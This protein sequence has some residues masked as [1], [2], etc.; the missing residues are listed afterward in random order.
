MNATRKRGSCASRR[1]SRCAR[2]VACSAR[3]APLSATICSFAIGVSP[4]IDG[5]DFAA[6]EPCPRDRRGSAHRRR[7]R[8]G[9]TPPR[10]GHRRAASGRAPLPRI[11]R[12]STST[13]PRMI[14][15]SDGAKA[16]AARTAPGARQLR[17]QAIEPAAR[18]GGMAGAVLHDELGVEMRARR[19]G[20]AR[21]MD[22]GERPAC[23]KGH[24]AA[25]APDAG[26]TVPSRSG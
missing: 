8:A 21:G 20:R 16:D 26:R 4:A 1:P 18:A 2:T 19:L 14:C 22:E 23:H 10:S 24:H 9:R 5:V 13:G 17:Q 6:R 7:H 3:G 25:P 15:G 12:V 11:S